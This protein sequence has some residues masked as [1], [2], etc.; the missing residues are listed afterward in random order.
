MITL[1]YEIVPER[2]TVFPK[3]VRF[4]ESGFSSFCPPSAFF[5]MICFSR[6]S[7]FE[8]KA[9]KKLNEMAK[10]LEEALNRIKEKSMPKAYLKKDR[11]G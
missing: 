6:T 7:L 10:G 11:F 5:G 3:R 4:R 1:S 2:K 8:L 9:R